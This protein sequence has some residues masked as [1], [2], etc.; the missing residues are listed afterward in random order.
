MLHRRSEPIQRFFRFERKLLGKLPG[1]AWRAF[2]G[3][4]AAWFDG[5][6]VV[7]GAVGFHQAAGEL[8][9]WHPHLHVLLTDGGWLPDGTFR[10][11]LAFD[12]VQVEK[13]FRAAVPPGALGEVLRFLVARGKISEEVIENLLTWRHP[14]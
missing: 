2:Q 13:L 14:Q 7:P 9:G 5:E 3:Y 11:L 8:L 12:P 1:C 6:E 10:H 4:F